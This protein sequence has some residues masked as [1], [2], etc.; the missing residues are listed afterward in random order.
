MEVLSSTNWGNSCFKPDTYVEVSANDMSAKID[1][2]EV[3]DN[4]I[5]DVPHPR[6]VPSIFAL[7]R[8]RGCEIGYEYAE[9]FMTCWRDNV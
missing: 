8:M 4:V 5:R 2:L 3:Y 1:A 6:S 9:G 7:A